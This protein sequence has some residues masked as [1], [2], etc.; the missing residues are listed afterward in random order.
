MQARRQVVARASESCN[1][2]A[3]LYLLLSLSFCLN[4]AL[5]LPPVGLLRRCVF[6][7]RVIIIVGGLQPHVH[8]FL[9]QHFLCFLSCD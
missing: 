5:P 1:R 8:T 3:Q 4:L 6:H 9:P 2:T 7:H